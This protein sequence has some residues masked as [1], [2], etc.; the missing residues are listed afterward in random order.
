MVS[1]TLD[2]VDAET[3]YKKYPELPHDYMLG[4]PTCGKNKGLDVD[5]TIFF[6]GEEWECNC[7]DQLQRHKQYLNAGIGEIYQR[8]TLDD[9]VGDQ[10]AKAEVVNYL[11]HQ[12]DL[13]RNGVGI[14]FTGTYGTGKTLLLTCL[15]KRLVWEGYSC[16][17]TTFVNLVNMIS[18]SWD[19]K[20][21]KA[22]YRRKVAA[23]KVLVIDD[24]GKE[25]MKNGIKSPFHAAIFDSIIRERV[26]NAQPTFITMNLNAEQ[27]AATYGESVISLVHEKSIVREVTGV[28]YRDTARKKTISDALAGVRR[29]IF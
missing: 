1:R 29:P 7:R 24:V 26:Q 3:L 20:E 11:N 22:E 12:K 25:F 2:L 5:G 13:V 15:L 17:F 4:C 9:Y 27:F 19:S 23:A 8:L 10:A 16:Y 28:S 18:G 14:I 21:D 6:D